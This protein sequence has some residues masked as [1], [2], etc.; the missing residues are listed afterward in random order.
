MAISA[1]HD[2]ANTNALACPATFL[3][4]LISKP[5]AKIS[6]HTPVMIKP[7]LNKPLVKPA[8]TPKS[9]SAL[10]AQLKG[11][12]IAMAKKMKAKAVTGMSMPYNPAIFSSVRYFSGIIASKCLLGFELKG[13]VCQLLNHTKSNV[14]SCANLVFV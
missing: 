13:F 3:L 7:L 4:N 6:A 14:A 2:K 11:G 1:K 9:L 10:F 8:T 12:Y 5:T